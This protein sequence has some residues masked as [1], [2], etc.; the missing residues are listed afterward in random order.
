[1]PVFAALPAPIAQSLAAAGVPESA[2]SLYVRE[3]GRE[4]PLVNHRALA[5]MNPASTMKIVTTLVGL[6]VL[7]PTYV[8]KTDFLTADA[9]SDGVLQGSLIIRGG[10]D[11]KF[12]WEHLQAAVKALRQ[13]GIR[14]I[15]GDVILDRTRFAPV[16]DDAAKFDGQPLRPYNVVTDALLYNFKSV[17]FRFSP[18]PNKTVLITTD[19]PTPDGLTIQNRLRVA[20]GA[21]GDWRGAMNA[22]FE[23]T[24]AAA[25]ASFT[26]TYAADCGERDW[27]V[28]LFD[29]SGILVGSF[30][31]LWRDAGGAWRGAVREARSPRE[32]RLLY[33][34]ASAP[35]YTMVSDINKFSNNVMAR[36]LLLTVDAEIA[37][38]PARADRGAR[39]IQ[40]WAKSRGFDVPELVIEN[41]AGLSR[42]ERI[43]AKSLGAF[44]EYG[45]TAPFAKD[46]VQS[47]PIAATDGTL[48]RRFTSRAVEGNAFLKT[49]TL[50]GV[51][52]LAGY[53]KM[54]DGK[55][56]IFVAMINHPRAESSV[57]V[58][59][60]A[61]E[62]V[63][64][65]GETKR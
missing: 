25:N 33:S 15:A 2:V 21:C 43:S 34:L 50:T 64:Q 44:L 65:S 17:G 38:A 23:S 42:N 9:L 1:M 48:A 4:A 51:A 40:S 55:S 8:W 47:L 28:S 13:Q 29:H 5:S 19:G 3:V 46:F 41:G 32:A 22:N 54:P 20:R 12:T 16:T 27:Y 31:R 60:S 45:L 37:K 49:G 35:L 30:A 52:T 57:K 14:E 62:W 7:S 63:Y 53:L 26:G 56:M 10:G 58:L 18:Q 24:R 11:P 39:S 6:D 59:D 61:V 36:Q